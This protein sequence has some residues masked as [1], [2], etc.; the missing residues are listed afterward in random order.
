MKK[1]RVIIVVF[2]LL[3]AGV[4]ALVYLG[5]QRARQADLAYSGTIE[6]ATI[7]ELSFQV[8]GRVSRVLVSEGQRVEMGRVLAELDRGEFEAAR[9]Q[10][11]AGLERAQK[12]VKQLE[13]VLEVNRRVLPADVTRAEAGAANARDV[14]AEARTDKE[15]YDQLLSRGVVSKKEWES[16]KLRFDTAATRLVEAE[17]ALTQATSSLTKIAA[18]ESE[19]AAA[20]AQALSAKAALDLADINLERTRL[21]APFAGI[22]TSRNLEPGEVVSASRQALSLSDLSTVKLKIYVGETEIGRVKPGQSA[23][24]RIDT[25]PGKTYAGT[26]SFVSPEGEFTPK[27]IQTRKERV[28]LVYQVHVTIPNPEMELKTGMPA[29]AWLK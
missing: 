2:V 11:R 20:R 7:S 28:K 19:V 5:Q 17:A 18:A 27:I 23:D 16:V 25:F 24:V 22:V 3:L 8:Q 10:A 26:V 21:T 4:A 6:A 15:R 12:S 13:A 9:Q 1:K 29:D 14:L